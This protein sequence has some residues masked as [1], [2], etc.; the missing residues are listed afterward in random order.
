M[1]KWEINFPKV[2]KTQ[3]NEKNNIFR[4]HAVFFATINGTKNSGRSSH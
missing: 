2:L 1:K 4:L 3:T